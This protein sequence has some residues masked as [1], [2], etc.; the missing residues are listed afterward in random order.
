ME[1]N[2]KKSIRYKLFHKEK[3]GNALLNNNFKFS[4]LTND[5]LDSMSKGEKYV[6]DIEFDKNILSK[7]GKYI[8]TDGVL[9]LL[10][11]SKNLREK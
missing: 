8:N 2:N 3:E 6:F 5:I 7:L 10:M 1:I 11:K 4:D 9:E